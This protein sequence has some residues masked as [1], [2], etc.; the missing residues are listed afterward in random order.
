M[1][2]LPLPTPI[3]PPAKELVVADDGKL[4]IKEALLFPLIGIAFPWL[5]TPVSFGVVNENVEISLF[6]FC[7][8]A[9]AGVFVRLNGVKLDA[10]VAVVDGAFVA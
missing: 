1:V 9:A 4:S 5:P 10:V 3:P 2:V 7:K 6:D 8:F